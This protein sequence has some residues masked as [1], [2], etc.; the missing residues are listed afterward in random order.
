MCFNNDFDGYPDFQTVEYKIA[1]K[2]HRCGICRKL[3]QKKE[4]YELTKGKFD[5]DFFQVKYCNLCCQNKFLIVLHELK[6]GCG[7]GEAWPGE[8]QAEWISD[9]LDIFTPVE[10]HRDLNVCRKE[11]DDFWFER[12]NFKRQF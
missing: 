12:T 6:E 8:W 5:G 10:T 3:I 2:E 1:K 7:W 11:V 4:Q 9:N